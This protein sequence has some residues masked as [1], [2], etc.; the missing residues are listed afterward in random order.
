MTVLVTGVTGKT[1]RRVVESL[2]TR[3]V[4]VRA[5][6]RDLERGKMA[7]LG[8]AVELVLG[9]FD[10]PESISAAAEGCDGMYL[11]V[12]DGEDQVRQEIGA[13][14]LAIEAGVEHIVKL[15]SSDAHQ[16][17]YAWSVAHAAVEDAISVMEV[18]YSFLRPHYFMENFFSRL[19]VGSIGLATLE[20]PT[21]DG[22]IGAI[23]SYDIG[24]CAG[25]LLA[26]GKPTGG[27]SLLTGPENIS[28]SRVAEAF[29]TAIGR[30]ISYVN[31]DA[32]DY[33][34]KLEA[35]DPTNND[36]VADVYE[37]VRVGTMALQS[38]LVE[39]ITGTPARSIEQFA[40]ANVDAI[41]AAI[42]AASAK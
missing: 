15:S 27:H 1:G 5:L 4:G 19:K 13:A 38:S 32:A 37:E 14:R 33:R 31:L 7:T 23:D 11:V 3:G 40:V 28:M 17:P 16:R 9:D 25:A 29:S 18:G 21:N 26:S 8:M 41:N 2:V 6:V 34:R 20:A 12:A 22:K 24:E 39:R 35:D 42:D 30:H 10:N 36:D